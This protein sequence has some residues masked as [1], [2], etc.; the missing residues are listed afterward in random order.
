MDTLAFGSLPMVAVGLTALAI[1]ATLLRWRAV[2][3]TTLV[4]PWCWLLAALGLAAW[5]M[6]QRDA[7]V[8]LMTSAITLCPAM[9]LFGA[10]RPQS[11]P[12]QI[13][14]ASLWLILALPGLQALL[15]SR[16]GE[17]DVHPARSWF[18]VILVACGLVN[19]LFSRYWACVLLAGGGQLI[20]LSPYLPRSLAGMLP[21]EAGWGLA[22]LALAVVL[23]ASWPARRSG[24]AWD[25]LWRDFRDAFGLVWSLRVMERINDTARIGGWGIAAGWSGFRTRGGVPLPG[26]VPP[27]QLHVFRRSLANLLR[28]FVDEPW[29]AQRLDRAGNASPNDSA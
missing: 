9:S 10:K 8:R 7:A 1:A 24:S 28:R 6:M 16:G 4:G 13:I 5:G 17:L 2:R 14:V 19:S 20:L 18:L 22:C 12:W 27:E 23:A 25:D 26:E 21:P 15:Y 3:G 29:M 11:G